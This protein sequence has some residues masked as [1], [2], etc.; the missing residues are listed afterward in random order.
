MAA[1]FDT[2]RLEISELRKQNQGLTQDKA[3][4]EAQLAD[5]IE[6]DLDLRDLYRGQ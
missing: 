4:L 3:A 1:Q 2:L 6:R 5:R